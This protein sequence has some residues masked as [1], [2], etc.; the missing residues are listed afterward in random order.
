MPADAK[1]RSKRFHMNVKRSRTKRPAFELGGQKI[2]PGTRSTID[3]PVSVLSTHTPMNLPVQVVHGRRDGPVM[4]VS[5]VVHG[6]EVMGVEIIR[7]LL[8]HRAMRTLRGTLLAVPIVNGF[9]FITHSRYLPDRRDLNRSFPGKEMGSLASMLAELFLREVVCRSD[10]GIDLHTAALHRTNLPQIR[11]GS[12]GDRAFDLAMAFGAPV[13]LLSKMREGSLRQAAKNEN[14]DVLVYEAGEALR[15]D[16]ISIRTGMMGILRV[17]NSVGMLRST[18]IRPSKV[19]SLVS[20]FSQWVRAP[21]GGL[22]RAHRQSGDIV[23]EGETIGI[24]ADPFGEKEWPVIAPLAG[25][26]IGRT[27][28]PVVNQ[29]DALFHIARIRSADDAEEKLN[30]HT[31]ELAMSALDDDDDEIL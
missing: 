27:N 10:L 24:V 13:V 8:R 26:I 25:I 11:V 22:L 6:D 16:E 2:P 14:V 20:T 15:F 7:R 30:L 21:D 19:A 28:L 12:R 5:A 9:G 29:G 23:A 3:V 1:T 4:F 18:T 31:E 17:M